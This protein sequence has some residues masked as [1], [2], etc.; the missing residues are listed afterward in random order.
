MRWT[1]QDTSW[2]S[3]LALGSL[4]SGLRMFTAPHSCLLL[5]TPFLLVHCAPKSPTGPCPASNS[6]R[7]LRS[8]QVKILPSCT[9]GQP[10]SCCYEEGGG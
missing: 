8:L 9:F 10:K 4:F 7:K 6:S 2:K 1:S 3:R 5:L